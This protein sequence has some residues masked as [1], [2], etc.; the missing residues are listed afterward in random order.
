MN[1][2]FTHWRMMHIK[3]KQIQYMQLWFHFNFMGGCDRVWG[4]SH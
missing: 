3:N 2:I 1:M 4:G